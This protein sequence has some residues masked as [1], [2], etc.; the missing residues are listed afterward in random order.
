MKKTTADRWFS[1]YIRLRDAFPNGYV[2]C[3]TCGTPHYWKEC[4]CG[5][6]ITRNHPM[7]RYNEENCNG[8][9]KG[10]NNFKSGD[11]FNHGQ[12][13]D[14]KYGKGTAQKLHDLGNI[15]GQKIHT[16]FHLK[17]IAKEYRIRAQELAKQKGIEI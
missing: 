14:K 5:H 10:C 13:I 9:C 1:I 16:K 11:Q 7:T 17:E 6:F 3:I 15:R 4:D 2:P 8:Q 12:M